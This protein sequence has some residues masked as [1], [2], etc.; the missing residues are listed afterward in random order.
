[1][2]RELTRD[3]FAQHYPGA[4][5]T[6]VG[7]HYEEMRRATGEMIALIREH[8]PQHFAGLP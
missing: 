3:F 5:L 7:E 1:M 6:Y 8:L 2:A 4:D